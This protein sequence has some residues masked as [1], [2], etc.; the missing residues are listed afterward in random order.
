MLVLPG[1]LRTRDYYRRKILFAGDWQCMFILNYCRR[2]LNVSAN[3][4]VS[5]FEFGRFDPRPDAT[6][7]NNHAG[8]SYFFITRSMLRISRLLMKKKLG[9]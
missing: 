6:K 3:Y 7:Q 8:T 5:F 1:T 4:F 2:R 9:E